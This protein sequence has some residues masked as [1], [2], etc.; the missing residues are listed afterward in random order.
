LPVRGSRALYDAKDPDA[1]FPP[2]RPVRPPVGAPNVLMPHYAVG[3]AHAMCTPYR[4]TTRIASHWGGTRNG[5]IVLWPAGIT[6]KCELRHQ[7]AHVIDVAPT[8]L[9]ATGCRNRRWPTASRSSRWTASACS[10]ASTTPLH[11]MQRLLI[12]EA[13]RH[14]VL[15]LDDRGF[16][17][18]LPDLSGRPTLV[19]D[20]QSLL[21]GMGA[22]TRAARRQLAQPLLVADRAGRDPGRRRRRRPPEPRWPP[23]RL[24]AVPQGPQARLRLQPLRLDTTHV[25]A[26]AARARR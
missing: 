12:I 26:G 9:D 24:V 19:G 10:T 15:P 22:L 7:F 17:R 23:G 6:A 13:T 14:N 18:V 20:K 3:W 11:E 2:I 5:T 8:V 16:E 4:W 25:R 1:K 21:A